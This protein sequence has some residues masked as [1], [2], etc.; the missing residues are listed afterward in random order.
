MRPRLHL[1]KAVGVA[2]VLLL[3]LAGVG[4]SPLLVQDALAQS[5][6]QLQK[7][8]QTV[9]FNTSTYKYHHHSCRYAHRC[10]DPRLF[11]GVGFPAKSVA[12]EDS[13]LQREWRK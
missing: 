9:Y 5:K 13:L 12:A 10:P 7:R 11:G 3:G 2:L 4:F 1:L 8:E 6:P